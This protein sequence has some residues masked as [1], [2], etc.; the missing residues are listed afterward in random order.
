MFNPDD[1]TTFTDDYSAADY[2]AAGFDPDDALPQPVHGAAP[3]SS[4][5]GSQRYTS[6]AAVPH[7]GSIGTQLDA[8]RAGIGYVRDRLG[9]YSLDDLTD[10]DRASS[11][12]EAVRN[13]AYQLI[14]IENNQRASDNRIKQPK[15]TT[16]CEAG[17][18][19]VIGSGDVAK[20]DDGHGSETLC[21]YSHTGPKAG[22]WTPLM[23]E[24]TRILDQVLFDLGV[25]ASQSGPRTVDRLLR[26]QAP[27]LSNPDSTKLFPMANG[28]VRF[29]QDG[30][31]TFVPYLNPDGSENI[32]YLN[33]YGPAA[34]I[35]GKVRARYAPGTPEPTFTAKDGY[36]WAPMNHILESCADPMNARAFILQSLLFGL[37]NVHGGRNVWCMDGSENGNGGGG[38]ST[39][40]AMIE[41]VIGSENTAPVAI[42]DL[43]DSQFG[44]ERIV[45]KR[46][47]RGDE[48]NA[49]QKKVVNSNRLKSIARGEAVAIEEKYKDKTSYAFTGIW[50]QAMNTDAPRFVEKDSALYRTLVPIYFPNTYTAAVDRKYIKDVWAPSQQ[51]ADYLANAALD[52]Y[53]DITEYDPAVIQALRSKIPALRASGS[54]TMSFLDEYFLETVAN[55]DVP[56]SV[57]YQFCVV[58][59]RVNGF[60]EPNAKTFKK[61]AV[62]WCAMHGDE[63]CVESNANVRRHKGGK[64]A[65]DRWMTDGA[66]T[67]AASKIGAGTA[68]QAYVQH[69]GVAYVITNEMTNFRDR[70]WF[71]RP[72]AANQAAKKP[73]E[74]N[75]DLKVS[76]PAATA[77]YNA[78]RAAALFIAATQLGYMGTMDAVTVTLP[79]DEW[80][81]AGF[82]APVYEPDGT[83]SFRACGQAGTYSSVQYLNAI[84]ARQ[85]DPSVTA[86]HRCFANAARGVKV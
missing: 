86:N 43:A 27:T 8:F 17:I 25:P 40:L 63:W 79:M 72:T 33:T 55:E 81:S 3:S 38:K 42:D 31:R 24:A 83:V 6:S 9:P 12:G 65:L 23:G 64:Y 84:A 18:A 22:T 32:D 16:T 54:T 75:A 62:Q 56:M 60:N 15:G 70:H 37:R 41:G 34:C 67:A 57:L 20:I 66:A 2:A 51:V 39:V 76:G 26:A 4:V 5:P 53:G 46:Y 29:D 59:C 71:T 11:I 48:T 10:A 82:L 21:Y 85:S 73:D 49:G 13:E 28:V 80:K 61:D 47:I 50:Y 14:S 77:P 45:G 44:G 52:A 30:S 68:V 78:Y 35:V 1:N 69:T 19:I 36:T 7:I 58:W 74:P